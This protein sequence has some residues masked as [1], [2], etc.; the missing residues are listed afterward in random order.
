MQTQT[1]SELLAK[2]ERLEG[3]LRRDTL[4][5]DKLISQENL[6]QI[7]RRIG[8]SFPASRK[9][10]EHPDASRPSLSNA[11]KLFIYRQCR[12]SGKGF[13][14]TLHHAALLQFSADLFHYLEY[15]CDLD[16]GAYAAL[17]NLQVDITE[18]ALTQ[19][20]T[21]FDPGL[22]VR[23]FLE[24]LV[25]VCKGYDPYSGRRAVAL[26]A[27]ADKAV[28]QTVESGLPGDQ[29]YQTAKQRFIA[30]LDDY[31]RE[32]RTYEKRLITKEQGQAHRDDARSLANWAILA[33]VA[34]STL[35]RVM[36][37]FLT[38]VWSKYLYITYLRHGMESTGWQRGIDDIHTLARSIA[39]GD[40]EEM[41]ALYKGQLLKLM[42]RF[43][44]GANSIHQDEVLISG[45]FD[46]LDAIH[47][48]IMQGEQ[49]EIPEPV[50]VSPAE[51]DTAESATGA[52]DEEERTL[53]DAMRVGDWYHMLNFG[54]AVRSR[55]IEKNLPHRYCLF[56]NYSGIKT[57]KY[58]FSTTA[59]ALQ[60]G[61]LKRLDMSPVFDKALDFAYRQLAELV[62]RLE[63][64]VRQSLQAR[65]AAQERKR[66]AAE[67]QRT[68][69]LEE[70]KL[71]EE[72]RLLEQRRREEEELLEEAH[73]QEEETQRRETQKRAEAARKEWEQALQQVLAEVDRLQPGAYLELI[74][75][76]NERIG[77]K[78]GLK[79]KS[80]RKL[81]FVDRFGDKLAE[82]RR[83]DLAQQIVQGNAGILDFGVAFDDTLQNLITER[84][85]KPHFD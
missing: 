70:E 3:Q 7:L 17:A 44:A 5:N 14:L 16:P 81:I 2:I 43:R 79:L 76:Q 34:G 55:L 75:E 31:N 60:A 84:N 38:E 20:D 47:M 13:L 73:R 50:E 59:A 77:C 30:F 8:K 85:K 40:P 65:D 18:I 46:T 37:R 42:A 71:R 1:L 19:P 62:P 23:H 56:A 54:V 36:L 69:E 51:A 28:R 21:L 80:T 83:E 78:L 74:T 82:F 29:T 11:V 41:F 27:Q 10:A 33:A 66:K 68:L 57:A 25:G 49:V 72:E 45:F 15:S 6:L 26:I 58:D 63:S 48:Q 12:P 22:P 61:T 35:P 52:L 9:S 32:T 4:H 67:A 64:R 24:F 53:P 39:I